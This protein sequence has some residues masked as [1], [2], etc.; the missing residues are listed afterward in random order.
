MACPANASAT[1]STIGHDPLFLI[2]TLLAGCISW[3]NLKAPDF[4]G[5]VKH[6]LEYGAIEGSSIPICIFSFSKFTNLGN[7]PLGTGIGFKSHGV[8]GTVN[9]TIGATC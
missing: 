9:I 1:S 2:V 8:C 5:T 7:K 4:F 6:R 3:I